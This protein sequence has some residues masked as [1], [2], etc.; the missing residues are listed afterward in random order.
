MSAPG[1]R[2]PPT[3]SE[4][5][6]RQGFGCLGALATRIVIVVVV[7]L[8]MDWRSREKAA[9][10]EAG[11]AETSETATRLAD[12][13]AKEVDTDG[14]FIRKP[15]GALAEADA[16]GRPLRLMYKS[17]TISETLEVRSAGPDGEFET[18]DDVVASHAS[19]VTN[20]ALAREVTGGALDAAKAR[21]FGKGKPGEDK[22]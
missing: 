14:R 10:L 17:G 19:R 2:R 9:R 22:K 3:T 1:P 8:V 12:E 20:H 15:E 4:A 7:V 6:F 5:F 18:R 21:L 16:W 11:R 13:I